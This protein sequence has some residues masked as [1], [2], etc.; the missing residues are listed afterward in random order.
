MIPDAHIV[1]GETSRFDLADWLH[2]APGAKPRDFTGSKWGFLK[3]VCVIQRG[4]GCST[5]SRLARMVS[6]K[7]LQ[8]CPQ[9]R[10]QADRCEITVRWDELRES[11]FQLYGTIRQRS[12]NEN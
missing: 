1:F 6:G 12:G 4:D 2:N 3:Q 9:A 7:A 10:S 5:A 8:R 11:R